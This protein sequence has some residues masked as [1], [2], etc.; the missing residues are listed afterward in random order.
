MKEVSVVIPSYNC[1]V[2]IEQA[3]ESV[4][5]QRVSVEILL[6][7]DASTD[8]TEERMKRFQKREEVCYIK[9]KKREGVSQ[10]RNRGILKAKGKYIAFLDAD[11]WWALEKLQ[12]QLVQ[13]EKQASILC[14]T[15]RELY[16]EQGITLDKIIEVKEALTYQELL[17][18]N[19]I[20]C[21]SVLLHTEVAKE[22]LM[23]HDEVHED[24]LMWLRIL[25]KYEKASGINE[26]LLK[27]RLTKE[28]KSRKKW[29]TFRMTYGVYRHLG[30]GKIRSFYYMGNH[31][32]RSGIK[33]FL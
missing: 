33:Y 23:E 20:A 8:D 22:F 29:K 28:G 26:P 15:G 27:T 7:D 25:K 19:E 17:H 1:G 30:I 21:S 3:I 12:K 11:D 16:S 9:N 13:I 24:Y 18:H 31:V 5:Q 32:I 4:L 10:A 6:I 2:Y 14:Y